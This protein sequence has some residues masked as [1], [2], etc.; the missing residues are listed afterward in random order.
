MEQVH[1]SK[2]TATTTLNS[3]STFASSQKT[4]FTDRSGHGDLESSKE[5]RGPV[6]ISRRV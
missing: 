6:A 3:Q 4:R 5:G 2:V 1:S